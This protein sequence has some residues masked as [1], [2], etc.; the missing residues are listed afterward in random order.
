M[1]D[2]RSRGAV[3]CA[4]LSKGIDVDGVPAHHLLISRFPDSEWGRHRHEKNC[5]YYERNDQFTD[6]CAEI[7]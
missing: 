4:P 3:L 5:D 1:F 6:H 2:V 7:S